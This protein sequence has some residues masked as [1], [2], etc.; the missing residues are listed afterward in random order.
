VYG[1]SCGIK[2]TDKKWYHSVQTKN[3]PKSGTKCKTKIVPRVQKENDFKWT[4]KDMVSSVVTKQCYEQNRQRIGDQENRQ[5]MISSDAQRIVPSEHK[6][7]RIKGTDETS[8]QRMGP[9]VEINDGNK[10][11]DKE[12]DQE[13]TNFWVVHTVPTHSL[14]NYGKLHR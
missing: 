12:G 11:T 3:C 2:G 4:D 9:S 10:W 6:K 7:N 14:S 13:D 8:V 5:I 1:Q